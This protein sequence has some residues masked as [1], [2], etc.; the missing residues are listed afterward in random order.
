[1]PLNTSAYPRSNAKFRMDLHK[2]KPVPLNTST[3]QAKTLQQR[4]F[5]THLYASDAYTTPV[6]AA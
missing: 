4:R 6:M 1:M 3:A 2:S 5:E